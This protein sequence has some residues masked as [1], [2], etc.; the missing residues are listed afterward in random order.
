MM[1]QWSNLGGEE[2]GWGGKGGLWGTGVRVW[3]AGVR[4]GGEKW[5]YGELE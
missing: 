4:L 5:D 2:W 3:V 1:G